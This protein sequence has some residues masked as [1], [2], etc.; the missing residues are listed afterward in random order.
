MNFLNACLVYAVTIGP[1][2]PAIAQDKKLI[3]IRIGALTASDP[4]STEYNRKFRT[5]FEGSLF[6]SLGRNTNKIESCGY[7]Y[8]L[9]FGYYQIDDKL[10]AMEVAKRLEESNAW[11][12]VG[13]DRSDHFVLAS[14][15][16]S[17]SFLVSALAG[18]NMATSLPF[19]TFTM[20]PENNEFANTLFAAA[21]EQKFG[22]KY[23]VAVDR[24][25]KFC[26]DFSESYKKYAGNPLFT[27]DISEENPRISE[28]KGF[29]KEHKPNYL[30]L[31]VYSRLAGRIISS[32]SQFS[33]LKFAGGDSWGDDKFSFL[34]KF[35][36]AK[37]QRGLTVRVGA[38]DAIISQIF[39]TQS[40][41]FSTDFEESNYV[42]IPS[43]LH[44]NFINQVTNLI[45]E[46]KPKSRAEFIEIVRARYRD[47][48]RPNL[49]IS[50]Y[51]L[52]DGAIHFLK[53]TPKK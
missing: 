46:M 15:G 38:S 11:V 37:H 1:V 45:C 48:F 26:T 7:R 23:A 13:P 50:V 28:L 40:L 8:E 10:S 49:G 20:S 9:S 36:I 53:Q 21:R 25:C 12:V 16:V 43:L 51:E 29:L 44:A 24:S 2:L 34:P 17:K 4:A 35:P 18:S 30:L 6:Y 39:E 47:T 19:P 27:F 52:R 42:P 41:R 32:L 3:P 31:P 22:A 14:K 33:D 5:A